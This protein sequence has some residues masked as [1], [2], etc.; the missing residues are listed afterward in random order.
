MPGWGSNRTQ[1]S[2]GHPGQAFAF[3]R[4][5]D[6]TASTFALSPP[7]LRHLLIHVRSKHPESSKYLLSSW[8]EGGGGAG[9][10]LGT[11]QWAENMVPGYKELIL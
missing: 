4:H 5:T 11:Q 9:L 1:V 7:M 2:Q 3:S 6:T 8:D 10:T